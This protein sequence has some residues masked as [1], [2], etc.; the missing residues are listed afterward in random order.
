[1]TTDAKQVLDNWMARNEQDDLCPHC[2]EYTAPPQIEELRMVIWEAYGEVTNGRFV[3][4]WT[5]TAKILEDAL[6]EHG[7]PSH[8]GDE[9]G[10]RGE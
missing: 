8:D 2:G 5:R 6:N 3:D 4:R 1:M 10:W 9:P 7:W